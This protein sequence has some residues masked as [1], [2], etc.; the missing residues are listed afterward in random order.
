M[1]KRERVIAAL[2]HRQTDFIPYEIG[3]TKAM[4]DKMVEFYGDASY[5]E[6]IGTHII[7]AYYDGGTAPILGK[8]DY[9]QDDFGVVW[10][11]TV[12]KD[13]GVVENI[14]IPEPDIS[15]YNFPK[16]PKERIRQK[17]ETTLMNAGDLFTCGSLGFSLFERA[18]SLVGMENLLIYMIS[19]PDFV[20]EL[21]DKILDFNLQV[22]D[23]FL[24][25]NFD[26]IFLADDWGQQSGLIM[27]PKMWRKFIKP[28]LAK[29]YAAAKEKGRFVMQHSCGDISEV[30]PDLI[31]IGLDAHQTF[32]PEIY[33]IV[34]IKQKYGGKLSFYGG[35]S[36]QRLLPFETPEG[37]VREAEKIMAVMGKGGGFIAAPTH[38]VPGDVP[39]ENID[40][41]IRLFQN[42]NARE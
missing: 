35:I 41:L 40:A 38:S 28:P 4:H 11:R 16:V 5:K 6:R 29:M 2:Q 31:E 12:D 25:Y 20:E 24:E 37:V 9:Y 32:Q 3:L 8:E 30:Y 23:V 21:M 36:T 19:D 34:T 1:T 22:I 13:I 18:W 26:C 27:G 14:L 10:N 17:S 33:D 7:S 15:L 42:Q 39:A